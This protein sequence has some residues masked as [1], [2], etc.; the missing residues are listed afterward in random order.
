MIIERSICLSFL[1]ASFTITA[2]E[3]GELVFQ[4]DFQRSE[5]QEKKDEPGKGWGT[6]SAKRAQGDKQVD[7]KD[8]AL[9]ST[10][11]SP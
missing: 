10:C 9:R 2:A 1:L 8:G 4:D 11:L 3:L 7:L 6:N 5:S